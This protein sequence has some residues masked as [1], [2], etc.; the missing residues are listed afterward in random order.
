VNTVTLTLAAADPFNGT[1]VGL[2]A[3]LLVAGAPL[4]LSVTD[5]LKPPCGI[6]SN[7]KPADCP[8]EILCDSA[9]ATAIAKS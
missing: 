6:T 5:W 3:Q 9:P 8:G 1:E 2:I 7:W 4:Q